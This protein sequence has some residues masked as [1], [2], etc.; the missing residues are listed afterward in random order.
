VNIP[1][2]ENT[3]P[4]QTDC[5]ELKRALIVIGTSALLV[6]QNTGSML[7]GIFVH[8]SG[9][10]FVAVV[11]FIYTSELVHVFLHFVLLRER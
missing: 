7:A 4:L 6:M 1:K 10:F 8:M 5:A 11:N 3:G 9:A 2:F